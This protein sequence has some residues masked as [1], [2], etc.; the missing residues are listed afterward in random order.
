V[1]VMFTRAVIAVA[2]GI[3]VWVVY[4]IA[5][6][7]LDVNRRPG[8]IHSVIWPLHNDAVHRLGPAADFFAVYHAGVALAQGSSPYGIR[9]NPA[10]TPYFYPFRY[11]PA[12]ASLV[13][14]F[15]IGFTPQ[16]AYWIWIAIIEATLAAFILVCVPQFHGRGLRCLVTCTLL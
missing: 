2:I 9:E 12:T 16:H 1:S 15:V 11:A 8:A 5:A 6:Q 10:V 14:R 13:G 7:P 4:T 3:H